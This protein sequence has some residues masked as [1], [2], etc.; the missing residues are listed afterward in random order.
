MYVTVAMM[1]E[2]PCVPLDGVVVVNGFRLS[3]PALFPLVNLAHLSQF[4]IFTRFY[5]AI[6]P[7]KSPA[8][9]EF[10]MDTQLTFVDYMGT[11]LC[12]A[13]RLLAQRL[14]QFPSPC[15]ASK[16]GKVGTEKEYLENMKG[17][18][19]KIKI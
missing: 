3:L 6:P 12:Y 10:L 14:V 18:L 7:W 8:K 13:A 19:F 15:V 17:T 1:G 5:M 2:Q 9:A 16:K 4:Q 11:I